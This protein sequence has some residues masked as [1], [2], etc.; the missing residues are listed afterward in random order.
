MSNKLLHISA[1]HV[2]PGGGFVVREGSEAQ[3]LPTAHQLLLTCNNNQ[4]VLT[5]LLDLIDQ[6][7]HYLKVCSFV[8][9]YAPVIEALVRASQ[10]RGVAVFVLTAV[11][12]NKLEAQF[13]EEELPYHFQQQHFDMIK[14]LV[15]AGAHV[16]AAG[17]VHAKFAIADGSA[18]IILSANITQ[19][20]LERNEKGL[21]PN[22]ES[23][24]NLAAEADI[25]TLE[26]LFDAIFRYGTPFD[27]F[28]M[29]GSQQQTIREREAKLDIEALPSLGKQEV[30]WTWQ[31]ENHLLN[32]LV[33]LIEQAEKSV[34][35]STYSI[36]GID[37]LPALTEAIKQACQ[38]GVSVRVLC[39]AMLHR[40][41]HGQGCLQL[42]AAGATIH[43]DLF[44]HSKGIVIDQGKAG[45]LFTANLD[46]NHGLTNG[47]EVGLLL[48]KNSPVLVELDAF[49]QWQLNTAP[50]VFVSN[51]HRGQFYKSQEW[52]YVQ[53]KIEFPKRDADIH[54]QLP[55]MMNQ[56]EELLTNLQEHP[57]YVIREKNDKYTA[58]RLGKSHWKV[59]EITKGN[60]ILSGTKSDVKNA[61]EHLWAYQNLV[62][63]ETP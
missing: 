57:L 54:M 27:R 2:L 18:G 40:P 35:L 43:A 63:E 26:Q 44:N 28:R 32:E 21:P 60:I 59:R 36:V 15:G 6:A 47:F 41:D 52:V 33:Q 30:R 56:K 34:V 1:Q 17:F 45:M 3:S 14:R 42:H 4:S 61:Q 25:Q 13:I 20:S 38:R 11:Q 8:L 9:N 48:E 53:K 22:P 10:E 46:G 39:R 37:K 23:G 55:N 7:E 49:M 24:V 5:A 51:A 19:P 31:Q 50:F 58:I 29:L 62:V 12:K 16:K